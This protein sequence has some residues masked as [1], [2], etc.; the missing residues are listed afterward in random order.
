[1]KK[2]I[3]IVAILIYVSVSMSMTAYAQD[4]EPEADIYANDEPAPVQNTPVENSDPVVEADNDNAPGEISVPRLADGEAGRGIIDA[5]DKYWAMN[6]YPDNISFAYEAGGEMLD[7][8]TSVAYWEIGIVNADEASK[9][10]IIDLLS[11]NCRITFRDCKW[12][13]SQRETAFNEIYASRGDIVLNVQMILNSEEVLVE[14]AD[15]YEKEYARKYIEQ[16][17]AFVGVTND[18]GAANDARAGLGLEK[19]GDSGLE[20]GNNKNN[21]FG[22]WLWPVCVI[23]LIGVVTALYVNRTRLIPAAQTNNGNIVTGNAPISR[24]QIIAA[25]K[26]SA[27]TPSDDVFRAIKEKIDNNRLLSK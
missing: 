3:S 19:G 4:D 27:L 7:D 9:Q 17:G 23:F 18:I 16:Y 21:A 24:K 6:G 10:E 25:V 5:P 20:T 14:I 8:V 15:G 11:P 2:I 26:R 1:M 12:S 22:G 13:Y